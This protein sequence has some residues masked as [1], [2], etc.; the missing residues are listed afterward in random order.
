MTSKWPARIAILLLF[1]MMTAQQIR[2]SHL[3]SRLQTTRE[4]LS[5]LTDELIKEKEHELEV[6][7]KVVSFMRSTNDSIMYAN[8]ALDAHSKAINT[9]AGVR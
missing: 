7:G 1:L 8:K 3:E 2:I 5:W 6:D 9:L 4:H